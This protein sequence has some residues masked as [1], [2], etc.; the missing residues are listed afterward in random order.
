M[1]L[2]ANP[3]FPNLGKNNLFFR[4]FYS[5]LPIQLRIRKE[6]VWYRY[7]HIDISHRFVI[8]SKNLDSSPIFM[9]LASILN[10]F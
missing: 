7:L 10:F 1:A 6:M 3:T 5:A 9:I 8:L 2:Q 4:H